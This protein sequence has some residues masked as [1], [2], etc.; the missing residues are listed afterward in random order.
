MAEC[1]EGTAAAALCT[2]D[3]SQTELSDKGART[4]R[5]TDGTGEIGELAAETEAAA[6]SERA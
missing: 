4:D 3:V 5:R 6:L 1:L 2:Y